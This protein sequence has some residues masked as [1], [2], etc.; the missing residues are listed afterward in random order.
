MLA[1]IAEAG[2]TES[3]SISVTTEEGVGKEIERDA[4]PIFTEIPASI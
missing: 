4:E 2:V 3:P 1:S